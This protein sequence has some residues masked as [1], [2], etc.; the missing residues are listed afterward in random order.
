MILGDPSLEVGIPNPVTFLEFEVLPPDGD[1]PLSSNGQTFLAV[2]VAVRVQN[3]LQEADVTI[4]VSSSAMG[5]M[6]TSTSRE[7]LRC[8]SDGFRYLVPVVVSSEDL[9]EARAIQDQ[10]VDVEVRVVDIDGNTATGTASGTL[11]RL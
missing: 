4:T 3:M 8:Q 5:T 11:R 2:Q 10:R 9:G 6:A 1:I 7:R